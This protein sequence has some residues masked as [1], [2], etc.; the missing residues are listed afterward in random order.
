MLSSCDLGGRLTECMEKFP[1]VD[2]S[3]LFDKNEK[4]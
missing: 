1:N 4:V 3:K 2:Y